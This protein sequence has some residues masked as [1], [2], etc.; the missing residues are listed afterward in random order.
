M[1][2]SIII[3]NWNTQ[4][5]LMHCLESIYSQP[6]H[7]DFETWVVDNASTDESITNITYLF[8]QVKLIVNSEN[9]GFGRANNQGIRQAIGDYILLLNPDTQVHT[10]AINTLIAYL[11]TCPHAA[12]VGPKLLNADGSLQISAYPT[13][14][15]VRELWRLF[16][17]DRIISIGQYSRKHFGNKPIKVDILMGACILLRAEVIKPI[18]LFDEAFFIYSEEVDLCE[19]IRKEGWELHWIPGPEV[20]HFGGVSTRQVASAMFLE[21]YRSKI[22]FFRKHRGNFQAGLYKAVLE[23]AALARILSGKVLCFFLPGN[24]NRIS[25][26]IHNYQAL[27]AELP[28]M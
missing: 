26:T 24:R 7:V 27:L 15:L 12:A 9:I 13:P 1:K 16:H 23:V 20:T 22:K 3:V 6:V 4:D 2:L 8:P 17:V 21:L 11:D 18:G 5:L 28:R 14:T 19:R 25:S 10:D